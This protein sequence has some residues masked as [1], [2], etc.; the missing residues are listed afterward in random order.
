MNKLSIKTASKIVLLFLFILSCS[1]QNEEGIQ[2]FDLKKIAARYPDS[3]C[4]A[5]SKIF[6]TQVL[7]IAP[8]DGHE[9]IVIWEKG[10]KQNWAEG[11]Y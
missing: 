6:G 8:S 10:D 9:G 11:K 7:K 5:D 1:R 4:V 3:T 2:A